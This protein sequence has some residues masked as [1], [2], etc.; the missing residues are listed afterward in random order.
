M[1]DL[2]T[3][4]TVILRLLEIAKAVFDLYDRWRGEREQI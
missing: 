2:D 3:I 4:L 1:S